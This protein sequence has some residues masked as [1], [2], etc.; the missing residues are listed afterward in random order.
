MDSTQNASRNSEIFLHEVRDLRRAQDEQLRSLRTLSKGIPA[1]AASVGHI[2]IAAAGDFAGVDYILTV[3][4]VG[5][6]LAQP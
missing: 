4:R 6:R 2:A 3:P 1:V 5:F